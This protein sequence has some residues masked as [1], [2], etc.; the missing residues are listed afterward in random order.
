MYQLGA[1]ERIVDRAFDVNQQL[2]L[3]RNL[4]YYR[5]GRWMGQNY[6]DRSTQDVIELKHFQITWLSRLLYTNNPDALKAL[7]EKLGPV[8]I[9]LTASPHNFTV[10]VSDDQYA[11]GDDG[12]RQ[13]TLS[14]EVIGYLVHLLERLER[15]PKLAVMKNELRGQAMAVLTHPKMVEYF[16]SNLSHGLLD[17]YSESGV[18]LRRYF[19]VVEASQPGTWNLEGY[20][21]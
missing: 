5:E 12:R 4:Q 11:G 14:S 9:E 10:N 16:T 7:I 21:H 20:R 1:Q 2:N 19:E 3:P 18:Y 13:T 8:L 15:D 17:G 6:V